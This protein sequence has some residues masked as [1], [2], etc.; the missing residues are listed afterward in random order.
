LAKV[1]Y[2]YKDSTALWLT[3]SF[4]GE[5]VRENIS[6]AEENRPGYNFSQTLS[7]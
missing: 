4:S 1:G 2:N 6:Q 7:E 3:Y 5:E